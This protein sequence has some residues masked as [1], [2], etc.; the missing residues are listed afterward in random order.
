[1]VKV[2]LF[3]RAQETSA[4]EHALPSIAQ[5]CSS[6]ERTAEEAARES[7]ELKLYELLARHVGECFDGIIAGVSATGFFVR[8]DDTAEG[9]VSLA[10]R[11]EYF[12]LDSVRRML[13]GSDSLTTYRLGM[14]VR[15]RVAAV[16]PYERRADFKLIEA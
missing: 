1:M 6:A 11:E 9:F 12:A 5:H 16:Y 4:Q 2:A 10:G 13:V 14:R 8:L 7:Q 15:V 3:G